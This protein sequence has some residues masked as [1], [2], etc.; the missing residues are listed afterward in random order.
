MNPA[1]TSGYQSAQPLDI[2]SV[3]NLGWSLVKTGQMGYTVVAAGALLALG[4]A[5][6]FSGDNTGRKMWIMGIMG[7]I[8]LG[9]VFVW[10]APW[11]AGLIGT[12]TSAVGK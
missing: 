4:F 3:L 7:S 8:V 11:L 6:A 9:G 10:G 2:S 5:L 12:A 1:D